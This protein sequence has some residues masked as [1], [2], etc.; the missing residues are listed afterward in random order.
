M[1]LLRDP[2]DVFQ[3]IFFQPALPELFQ[4]S[5]QRFPR[6]ETLQKSIDQPVA[7]KM[8]IKAAMHEF[9]ARNALA[10]MIELHKALMI[11]VLYLRFFDLAPLALD[12]FF[13]GE[14]FEKAVN[15]LRPFRIYYIL[16]QTFKQ[17]DPVFNIVVHAVRDDHFK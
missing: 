14:P 1:F 11:G 16:E 3:F 17:K 10:D 7:Q 2:A 12:K 5:D 15:I 13:N 8:L 9:R 6:R 4:K